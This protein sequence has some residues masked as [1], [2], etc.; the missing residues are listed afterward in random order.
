MQR[1]EPSVK[2]LI[3]TQ[4]VT[5]RLQDA[6]VCYERLA[7]EGPLDEHSL[8]VIG[9]STITFKTLFITHNFSLAPCKYKAARV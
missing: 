5:G 1:T 4:I 3:L 8:Q 7:Q 9:L 2:Q 6:A